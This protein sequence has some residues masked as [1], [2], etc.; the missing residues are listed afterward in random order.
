MT[1][2]ILKIPLKLC[3][4]YQS[5]KGMMQDITRPFHKYHEEWFLKEIF[6]AFS[7]AQ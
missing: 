2:A 1:L 4:L 3:N 7:F 5:T 6:F